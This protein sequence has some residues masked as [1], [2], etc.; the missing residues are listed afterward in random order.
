MDNY[1]LK[2]SIFISLFITLLVTLYYGIFGFSVS[3]LSVDEIKENRKLKKDL[4]NFFDINNI[5]TVYDKE[6]NIYYYS[7]P[8]EYENTKYTLKLD[9]DNEY[10]YKIIGNTTNIITVDYS[11]DYKVIIYNDKN[12]YETKIRLTNLP[13]ISITTDSEITDNETNSVFKY[14][15]PSNL[16]KEMT[17]NSKINIRGATTRWYDKKSYKVKFFDEEYDK[18]KNVNISNFY[19]GSSFILDAMYRDNSKIRNVLGTKI[20]NDLSD[21]FTNADMYSEYVEVFI[22]GKYIGLYAFAEPV[23]RKNLNLNKSAKNDTSVIIKSNQWTTPSKNSN[24]VNILSDKYMDYELKYPNDEELFSA[25]WQNILTKLSNYYNDDKKDYKTIS[26]SFNI[27]NYIDLILFNSFTNNEDNKFTKNNYFYLKNLSDKVHIQPWDMEFCFGL[28]FSNTH[29]AN[30]EEVFDDY[31]QIKFDIRHDDS[32]KI[33][34]LLINRYWNFRRSVLTDKYIDDTIDEY[35][36][37]LKKGAARRDSEL[38]LDYDIEKEIEIVRTWMHKR[39]KIYDN[40]IRN[41]EN[42]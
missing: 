26:N 10:K 11:K 16:D 7:I 36:N 5:E 40:Y 34:S 9:L 23:N 1:K 14:I 31:D 13:L 6:S 32:D 4:I 38:W 25:S 21:D 29:E 12:Y 17:Y 28:R 35:L 20:W 18:E 22:N 27:N 39:I 37:D 30:Y 15:N 2:V 24:F 19:Y 42:E 8:D 33:N 3:Y 41:L